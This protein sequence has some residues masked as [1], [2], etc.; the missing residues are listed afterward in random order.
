M[1]ALP[2]RHGTFRA[3]DA[4]VDSCLGDTDDY[5]LVDAYFDS[6]GLTDALADPVDSERNSALANPASTEC[7][8]HIKDLAAQ[9]AHAEALRR[10]W[11][12]DSQ[13]RE[14][15]E[16]RMTHTEVRRVVKEELERQSREWRFG[17]DCADIRETVERLE[18]MV[19]GLSDAVAQRSVSNGTTPVSAPKEYTEETGEWAV[20]SSQQSESAAKDVEI[21]RLEAHVQRVGSTCME[22]VRKLSARMDT[23]EQSLTEYRSSEQFVS[24]SVEQASGQEQQQCQLP[25]W[26]REY[27]KVCYWPAIAV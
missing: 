10:E 17:Q 2:D 18:Q 1:D 8:Q 25:L 3:M 21:G 24:A 4:G 22:A 12:E 7:E 27:V 23:L 13:K 11:V 26:L 19:N 9:L 16:M 6:D 14:A 15:Q 5:L 20:S